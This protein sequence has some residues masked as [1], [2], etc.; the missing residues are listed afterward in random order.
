MK[1]NRF[2]TIAV[3]SILCLLFLFSIICHAEEQ[4]EEE[5]P[6]VDPA[7][8]T[9]VDDY[10][11]GCGDTLEILVWK[12]PDLSK[13]VFVRLDGKITVPLLDDIPAAGKTPM[14]LKD[15]IQTGFENFI[16]GPFVSVTLLEAGS[17]KFYMIGEINGTRE[18]TLTKR[19]TGLQAFALGGGFTDWAKKTK[20]IVFRKHYGRQKDEI[21]IINYKDIVKGKIEDNIIIQPNDVIIVP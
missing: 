1:N 20:I 15:E 12:E 9:L 10:R 17:Q 3:S 18:Y 21:L 4:E 5:T 7:Y 19:L 14:E 8:A 16:E 2:K 13:T 6:S 11:I